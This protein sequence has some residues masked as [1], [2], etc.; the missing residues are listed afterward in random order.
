MRSFTIAAAAA[1]LFASGCGP[2][3]RIWSEGSSR[4]EGELT[5]PG[6]TTVATQVGGLAYWGYGTWEIAAASDD[7]GALVCLQLDGVE[8]TGTFDLAGIE[9]EACM[10][11]GGISGDHPPVDYCGRRD[12]CEPL[13]GRLTVVELQRHC[14]DRTCA[15]DAEIEVQASTE[16]GLA[17]ALTGWLDEEIVEGCGSSS[18]L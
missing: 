4:I 12:L 1:Q 10:P 6:R 5:L 18:F 13:A 9:A 14:E 8:R 2:C 16:A 11:S 15:T 7:G 17:I 3:D